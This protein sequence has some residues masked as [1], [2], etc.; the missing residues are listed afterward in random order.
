MQCSFGSPPILASQRM[1]SAQPTHQ[2]HVFADSD[3]FLVHVCAETSVRLIEQ[4]SGVAI[5]GTTG[6]LQLKSHNAWSYVCSNETIAA[7]ACRE[8]GY[9]TGTQSNSTAAAGKFY[10]V[11]SLH[12]SGS[13]VSLADCQNT[14]TAHCTELP[15]VAL[16]CTDT[17]SP[18]ASWAKIP[19]VHCYYAKHSE[20]YDTL[21]CAKAACFSMR[22]A[23][24]GVYDRVCDDQSPFY[25]CKQ[26]RA[27]ASSTRSCVYTN[28]GQALTCMNAHAQ[29]HLGVCAHGQ[30][31]PAI[32]SLK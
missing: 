3:S 28:E 4:H 13:E 31:V 1:D 22:G 30:P 29:I 18:V 12:C 14:R 10:K 17:C 32:I 27:F 7:R 2:V 21:Q 25:L 16:T 23:C 24:A 15:A 9:Q 5:T 8:L 6:L 11:A 19:R 20:S 26:D